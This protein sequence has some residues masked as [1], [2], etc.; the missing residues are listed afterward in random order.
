MKRNLA[1]IFPLIP[2][3]YDVFLCSRTH[4]NTGKRN[5]RNS[6][7]VIV[8]DSRFRRY[9]GHDALMVVPGLF[10]HLTPLTRSLYTE[11]DRSRTSEFRR[12]V[13]DVQRPPRYPKKV[14][15]NSHGPPQLQLSRHP[16]QRLGRTSTRVHSHY[17]RCGAWLDAEFVRSASLL[18]LFQPSS[19]LAIAV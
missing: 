7:S 5:L 15:T 13:R 8:T 6:A 18:P 11:N 3:I 10:S 14:F 1:L 9:V 17:S 16:R 4:E 19:F 2:S 12:R